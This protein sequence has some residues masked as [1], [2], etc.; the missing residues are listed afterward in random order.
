MGIP[1]YF[2]HILD[3]YRYLLR[4]VDSKATTLLLD[5]NCLIYGCIRDSKMPAYTYETE[6]AYESALIRII[7]DYVVMLWN[8]SGR[9]SEVYLA[10]DG[11]VPMA[12]IKQQRL[13]RFKSVWMTAKEREF[14]VRAPGEEVWDTNSITP[15]TL[16]MEKLSV[17][18]LKL[19]TGRTG[20]VLSGAEEEG[21][22]EQKLMAWI[23]AKDPRWFEGQTI[24]IY[25]LD[26]D[27]IILSMLHA[28]TVGSKAKW[29]LLREAQ[30]FSGR[31]ASSPFLLLNVSD[32]VPILFP[33]PAE[34]E[35][36]LL[37]YVAGMCLLGNDF[38]PHSIGIHLKDG[39]HD[40]LTEELYRLHSTG[41]YLVSKDLNGSH[42]TWNMSALLSIVSSWATTEEADI[43]HSFKQKSLQ[44]QR[45]RNENERK[46]L[47]VS[48]LPIVWADENRIYSTSESIL[49][50]GWQGLYYMEQGETTPVR[51]DIQSRCESYCTGL[52]WI[53]DY[54][55]GQAPVSKEW[56]YAWT[57]PP[58]WSD[59]EQY[60]L[61][62]VKPRN[63]ITDGNPLK[64]Q[65]QLTLVLPL[66]SFRLIRDPALK[67]VPSRIPYFWPKTFGFTSLGKRMFW[68]C[69]PKIP[70]LTPARLRA[71][72]VSCRVVLFVA[73]T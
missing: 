21:E 39:G 19:C 28:T 37:D 17:E 56:M 25:G 24:F 15:G 34:R 41:K 70:I 3:R 23:R 12:K 26:A 73:N 59:L 51:A 22:G 44:R 5:F 47:P 32:F 53:L 69:P 48:N 57:Y 62:G 46:M 13:R 66:E 27:L 72:D 9:P 42:L 1:S 68:E 55:T 40:R 60:L 36:H 54:Y 30:E 31:P 58:L 4:P 49:Y 8:L 64:P 35:Q 29:N 52:Q 7:K 2:K 50:D 43:V 71:L 14:G 33:N 38:V 16:F 10:V 61:S 18:L 67:S 11:V 65:E 20:W 63:T 6:G 45:P